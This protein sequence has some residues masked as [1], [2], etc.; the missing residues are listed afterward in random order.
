MAMKAIK[1]RVKKKGTAGTVPFFN[2]QADLLFFFD[3]IQPF[4]DIVRNNT[5][6]DGAYESYQILHVYSPPFQRS[7]GSRLNNDIRKKIT[8]PMN[9]ECN[10]KKAKKFIDNITYPKSL[11]AFDSFLPWYVCFREIFITMLLRSKISADALIK[12][13]LIIFDKSMISGIK[14][15]ILWKS[16]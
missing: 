16:C 1:P 8:G 15:Q 7:G 13:P 9:R 14:K 2:T 4:T 10:Q 6:Y 11:L 12:F 3:S 5:C